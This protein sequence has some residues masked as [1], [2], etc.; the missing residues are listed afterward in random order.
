MNGGI[1]IKLPQISALALKGAREIIFATD[2]TDEFGNTYSADYDKVLVHEFGHAIIGADHPD[3]PDRQW[4]HGEFCV[5]RPGEKH[6][7]SND[8]NLAL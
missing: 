3:E 5:M 2:L 7:H 8:N 1:K 4:N 6:A